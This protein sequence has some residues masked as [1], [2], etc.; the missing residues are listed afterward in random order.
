MLQKT[1]PAEPG[2][3]EGAALLGAG[4]ADDLH[5]LRYILITDHIGALFY[6]PALITGDLRKGVSQVFGMLQANVGNDRRLRGIYDICRIK[7]A[8]ETDLQD[9]N[10]T[11]FLPE[12]LHSDRRD[13]LEMSRVFLHG[14]GDLRHLL[15]DPAQGFLF[16]IFPAV[17]DPLPEILNIGRGIKACRIPGLPED[18]LDHRAGTPLAVAAGHMDKT[19]VFLRI[20]QALQQLPGPGQP[21]LP[22]T[23]AICI[24]I[25]K[26]LFDRH[27]HSP[28]DPVPGSGLYSIY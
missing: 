26:C 7:G 12:I 28:R 13:Q 15:R 3:R 16:D 24:K 20:A 1:D 10:I 25:I 6:D 5:D 8:A 9:D 21:Q 22:L 2:N 18:A 17:P 4:A 19:Q 27:S 14:V 11:L 23:P